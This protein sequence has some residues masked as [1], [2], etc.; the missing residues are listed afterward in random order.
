M[1]IHEDTERAPGNDEAREELGETAGPTEDELQEAFDRIVS[2]G[3]QRLHRSWR[4]VLTTGFAG[5]LE[6][7]TG[8]LLLLAVY[9]ETGSH[10][11]AGLAFSVG[12]I[13]L[14][15]AR[16]ELFTEGFLVP[17]TAV[18]AGR[19][20]VAQ[21]GKL[22]GGTLVANLVG[23][24]V[25]TWL[26]AHGFPELRATAIESA[27]EFVDSPLDLRAASLAVLAGIAITLMTRMQQGTD[28]EGA[29]IVAAVAGAFVLAGLVL[30]HSILDSLIIFTALHAGAPFGYV[31]WLSWF[32][33]TALLNMVGGL[34]VVTALRLVRSKDM[35][36][37]ERA[38]AGR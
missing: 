6:V 13:A 33:Y 26:V 4:E 9:H 8:V 37:E 12:F 19:A 35:I 7:A 1:A 34:F 20:S 14:L 23:G 11:L 30:F 5:G 16:S 22:W 28:S 10:L 18:F 15:L 25:V 31:D 32:W 17:V 27:V 2:E 29:K 24:W 21:L 38:S 36:K 3:A